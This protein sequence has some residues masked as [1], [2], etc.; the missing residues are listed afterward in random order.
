[1]NR[2]DDEPRRRHLIRNQPAVVKRMLDGQMTMIMSA[3]WMFI[4]RFGCFCPQ[5]DS[6]QCSTQMVGRLGLEVPPLR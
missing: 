4:E 2:K 6:S 1:M 5:W 3:N